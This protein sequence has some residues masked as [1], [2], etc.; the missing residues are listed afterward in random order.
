[1]FINNI[2]MYIYDKSKHNDYEATLLYSYITS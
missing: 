2:N 1:M